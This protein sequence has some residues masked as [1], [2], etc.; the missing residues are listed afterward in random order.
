[1]E[2]QKEKQLSLKEKFVL[3]RSELKVPKG[4]HNDFGN[5]SFRSCEDILEKLKPL[6]A[7]YNVAVVLS[8]SVEYIPI[9][10][11]EGTVILADEV[12][13]EDSKRVL[14]K[15]KMEKGRF[16]V[17][18]TA[19]LY[20]CDSDEKIS[21][22]AYAREEDSK[23]GMDSSQITGT[24]SSYAR[25]YALSG[26][27]GLDDVKDADTN[28]FAKVTGGE[29]TEITKEE[30]E[31]YIFPGGKYK[32]KTL[33]VVYEK[34]HDYIEWLLDNNKANPTVKKC[35]D[36][37]DAQQPEGRLELLKEM[38]NL[39]LK[40]DSS[41]EKLLS[42]YG[43]KSDTELSIEQIKDAIATMEKYVPYE[44]N[45]QPGEVTPYDF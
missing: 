37:L 43:V 27:F 13:D 7:K 12:W 40:T 10:L 20:D 8:D 31:S 1:M 16:Y 35:I 34:H 2:E 18:A 32:G 38:K 9:D 6:E 19:T 22:K 39:E 41:H 3:I 17:E 5:Y 33:K 15:E 21:N 45:R 24:A 42:T 36:I 28:E 26:L 30:A 29:S 44:E 4:Q 25:K 23:K 11:R 14:R